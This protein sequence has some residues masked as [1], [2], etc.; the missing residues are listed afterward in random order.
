MNKVNGAMTWQFGMHFWSSRA[1]PP[2]MGAKLIHSI[3]IQC[4]S[5]WDMCVSKWDVNFKCVSYTSLFGGE[6]LQKVLMVL[7]KSLS[8]YGMTPLFSIPTLFPLLTQLFSIP[9]LWILSCSPDYW[10]VKE[11]G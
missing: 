5:K 3:R 1:L 6:F 7:L 2:S 4:A 8:H 11:T 9:T 10:S